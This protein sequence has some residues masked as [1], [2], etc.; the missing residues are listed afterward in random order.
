[1]PFINEIL[2]YR[3]LS[4]VG[5]EKNTGKTECLNY[6]LKR[7]PIE[8]GNICV[9]SIG[10]DGE[11]VDQVTQTAKP[12][13]TLREG[14]LFATAEKYYKSRTII[15]EIVD[16]FD[17]STSLGRIITA[18]VLS[19]GKVLLSGPSS[20]SS[21]KRWISSV[22]RFGVDLTIIDGALSRMSSASPAVS[23]AMILSTGA[24]FSANLNT[25]VQKTAFIVNLI[26]LPLFEYKE[27]DDS[28]TDVISSLSSDN[29]SVREGCKVIKISGAL[30][31]RFLK[32]ITMDRNI[33]GVEVVVRDF[34]RIF[35]TPQTYRFFINAGGRLCVE[36]SSKL[37]AVCVN[38]LSPNG[39]AINSDRLCD[40]LSQA[41]N[42]PVY[43]IVKNSY[44]A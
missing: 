13:I 30:T 1:M 5:L 31:D 25:L 10:I 16:I 37:I 41:I 42:L 12:E 32:R 6:V 8:A 44:E 19:E 21:L 3:S 39:Y 22:N 38:P 20:T 43:D 36:G 28:Q 34:T 17:E 4:I 24:A 11:S 14:V 33:R 35:I 2:K 40:E 7:L 9:T 15:S 26:G 27:T 18:R 23:E 29:Y